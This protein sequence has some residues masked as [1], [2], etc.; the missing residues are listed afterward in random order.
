MASSRLAEASNQEGK[1]VLAIQAY[2]KGQIS[3]L[4]KASALYAIPKS[5][6][7]DQ[8][9]GRTTRENAQST[10]RKLSSTAEL[11]LIQWILAMDKRGKAP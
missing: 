5:T 7:H 9:K 10:N 2:K 6:L 3:S 4:R 1:I 8:S 11:T